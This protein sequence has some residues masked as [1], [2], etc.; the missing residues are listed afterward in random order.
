M[1][2]PAPPHKIGGIPL[3]PRRGRLFY[4]DKASFRQ[5]AA[6]DTRFG[7]HD[8]TRTGHRRNALCQL[9][10]ASGTGSRRPAWRERSSCQ[11]DHGQSDGPIRVREGDACATASRHLP[12]RIPPSAGIPLAASQDPLQDRQRRELV[13][14]RSRLTVALGLLVPL[15]AVH[16]L[17]DHSIPGHGWLQ[18]ALA[19]PIQLYVGW[20]YFSGALRRLRNL[21]VSMDTLVALGTGVAYA[22]GIVGLVTSGP[23]MDFLDAA[24]ILTFIT[25]GK[26]LETRAKRRTSDA[27]RQLVS[28]SPPMAAVLAKPVG[29]RSD[30]R[31]ERGRDDGDL[32]RRSHPAGWTGPLRPKRRGRVLVD[33]RVTPRRQEFRRH[34]LLGLDQRSGL[35]ACAAWH[36]PRA[37]RPWIASSSLWNTPSNRRRKSNIWL[38]AWL[39]GLCPPSC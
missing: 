18:F 12:G 37:T 30:C 33:R 1:P 16:G 28:L 21:T 14:W 39:L 27:I 8:R 20:P 26:Y 35:F 13:Y 15:L 34:S 23:A 24:M 31:S 22:A 29:S 2:F 4:F 3:D 6:V 25:L 11:P 9:R 36:P 32:S 19:T 17:G 5:P 38:T 7:N 10:S